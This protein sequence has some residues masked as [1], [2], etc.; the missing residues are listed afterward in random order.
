VRGSAD[1]PSLTATR[2]DDYQGVHAIGELVIRE[3]D[4]DSGLADLPSGNFAAD[5]RL[6]GAALAYAC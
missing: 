2:T 5:S 6:S 1:V 4:D 3:L